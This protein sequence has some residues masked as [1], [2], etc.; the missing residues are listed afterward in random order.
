MIWIQN[1]LRSLDGAGM[2][3][4]LT[5]LRPCCG[6]ADPDISS[7]P[8][9]T[10]ACKKFSLDALADHVLHTRVPSRHTT[11]QLSNWLTSSAQRPR[12]RQ[13]R[14]PAAGVRG[15]ETS[16]W[17][18]TWRTLRGPVNLVRNV[19][20]KHLRTMLARFPMAFSGLLKWDVQV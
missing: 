14:W 6:C 7:L 19:H 20:L 12:S 9:S 10:C 2:R 18:L 5:D 17:R 13:C 1:I 16:S 3:Q 15:V 11:G 8:V 4:S